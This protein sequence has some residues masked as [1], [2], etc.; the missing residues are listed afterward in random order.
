M[1]RVYVNRRIAT[2]KRPNPRADWLWATFRIH[3]DAALYVDQLRAA[4]PT[5]TV[6][7]REDNAEPCD[8]T[9][10]RGRR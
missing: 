5:W 6:E 3:R 4:H 8:S 10:H 2:A 1:T 7:L 9:Y